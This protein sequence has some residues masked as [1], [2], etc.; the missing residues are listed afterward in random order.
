M[1]KQREKFLDATDFDEY[2][3]LVT[4]DWLR[5]LTVLGFTL[6]PIFFILDYFM[7][8]RENLLRFGTYRVVVTGVIL[9]QSLFIKLTRAS[10]Y[11]ILHG[12][13]FS[14][15]ATLMIAL[16]TV[17]LGGFSS[18]Y[19][20]GI[21]LVIIAT[22]LLIPWRLVHSIANVVLI[23]SIY[24]AINLIFPKP[25]T[26]Q[27]LVN[28]LY[29]MISTGVI[30][31]SINFVQF[32]LTQREFETRQ[33]L[34]IAKEALQGEMEIAK[35]IQTRLLP[36]SLEVPGYEI[37]AR[38]ITATEVGGDYYDIVPTP[39]GNFL[40]IG[41]VAGHGVDSGLI[42]MMTQTSVASLLT[43][44]QNQTL[45]SVIEEVNEILTQNI[46]KLD[47]DRY[48]SLLVLKIDAQGITFAGKHQ[49]IKIYRRATGQVESIPTRGA[50]IGVLK[51]IRGLLQDYTVELNSGDVMLL[52]TDGVTEAMNTM[53]ELYGEDR[54]EK[55]LAAS[56]NLSSE[57]IVEKIFS[58]VY[59]FQ[60]TQN[61]DIT[62]LACK[63]I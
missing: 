53:G 38:M 21:N 44:R 57:G 26:E 47:V 58:D 39:G 25:V 30:S 3:Q 46:R 41:D 23:I 28:N 62:L 55:T 9:L 54:L 22:M 7:L 51:D 37:Y 24:V 50:W 56:A 1:N 4:H 49:D 5:T 45:S 17:D 6:I 61:D 27:I 35:M 19:Y 2:L 13:F 43:H 63:K 60:K 52:F 11:S 29:F 40:A 59:A 32:R 48:M 12:Y 8:P 14:A 15:V 33:E 34:K 31:I 20:A 42:M 16:M 10:P 36:K 18:S